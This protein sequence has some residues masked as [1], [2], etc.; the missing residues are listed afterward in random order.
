MSPQLNEDE[1]PTD[2]V[3]SEE[4]G[5]KRPR[6]KGKRR[7]GVRSKGRKKLK[8]MGENT[9]S[10][11][12]SPENKSRKR[13]RRDT[14]S[15]S[16]KPV[17]PTS[18]L[19]SPASPLLPAIKRTRRDT[20]SISPPPPREVVGMDMEVDTVLEPTASPKLPAINRTR[21]DTHSISPP[22][23][24]VAVG[25]DGEV[26]TIRPDSGKRKRHPTYTLSPA[27]NEVAAITNTADAEQDKVE[28]PGR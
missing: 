26:D 23:S 10:V 15:V 19:E 9:E 20:H 8:Q 21:R 27:E 6:Q 3:S 2:A 28:K 16:P 22:P 4:K 13:K 18:V 17:T 1:A 14:Y 24:R 11:H 5:G 12:C 7:K 25:I